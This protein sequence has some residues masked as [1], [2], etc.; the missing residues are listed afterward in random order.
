MRDI[1]DV[2]G[3]L[4]DA[5]ASEPVDD[6]VVAA[7]VARG[8]RALILRHR[9]RVVGSSVLAAA[10]AAVITASVVPSGGDSVPTMA[11]GQPG[12]QQ[13]PQAWLAA[14]TGAQPAGFTVDA[15]PVGWRVVSSNSAEFL[16]VPPGTD[17]SSVV[18]PGAVRLASGIAVLLQGDHRLPSD[19]PVATVTVHGK[20]AQLGFTMD[21]AAQWLIFPDSTGHKVLVQVP[22][23]LGLTTDQ[24]V[25]FADG[26]T[27]TSA[28][29][30]AMGG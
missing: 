3:T 11:I 20:A 27:V 26:I 8:H 13:T 29:K 28:A 15:V 4:R 12:T 6:G 14:Y 5:S 16:I 24:I 2:L 1:T 19:S 25:L 30:P 9:R 10:A 22:T 18:R 21:K 7:D 17:T 23:T